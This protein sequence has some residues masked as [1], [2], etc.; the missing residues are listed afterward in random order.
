MIRF[1]SR[2]ERVSTNGES[3]AERSL[4]D[5]S[6]SLMR[7]AG[8]RRPVVVPQ[9]CHDVVFECTVRPFGDGLTSHRLSVVSRCV[10]VL[11]RR[12]V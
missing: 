12:R 8:L 3:T 5:A 7:F 4:E 11:G 9:R 1:A 6:T 10:V 2:F